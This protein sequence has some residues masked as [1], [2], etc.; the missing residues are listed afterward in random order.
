MPP[1]L[2]EAKRQD[3]LNAINTSDGR[4]R[5][6]IA[7]EF[8]VAASTVGKIA[9]EAGITDAFDRTQTQKGTQ[10]RSADLAE[11]RSLTSARFLQEATKMLDRL[12]EP[13][14]VF[15]FGGAENRFNSEVL[16]RPPSQ[17]ARNFM[18]AAAV[19]LDKHLLLDKHD[20]D[21]Q[22]G[23][24]VDSWLQAMMGRRTQG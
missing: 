20:S 10:A 12:N 5:N 24:A 7:K 15:A 8:G 9:Q 21:D 13:C 14:E 17:E 3:I 2:N 16:H 4:S 18:T 19:A 23:A 22:S 1:P 6:Q 11:L